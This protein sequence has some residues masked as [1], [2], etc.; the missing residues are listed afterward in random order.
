[1][2]NDHSSGHRQT[3][4]AS[5]APLVKRRQSRYIGGLEGGGVSGVADDHPGRPGSIPLSGPFTY[6]EFGTGDQLASEA[7][8]QRR[9][10]GF[11]TDGVTLDNR[12]AMARRQ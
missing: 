4:T 12:T 6:D 1:V 3:E 11:E 10:R 7:G 8:E 2:L 5:S 9:E